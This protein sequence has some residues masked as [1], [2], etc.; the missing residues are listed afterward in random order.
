MTGPT[1]Q[2]M[3][4]L[5]FGGS[6]NRRFTQ[7]SPIL[8]EVWIKYAL[9]PHKAR[10]LILIPAR[11][12]NAGEFAN[13]LNGRLRAY[14]FAVPKPLT[15][16]IPSDLRN[17]K[18]ARIAHLPGVVAARLY[19]DE[20]LRLVL[21]ATPWW[22]SMVNGYRDKLETLGQDEDYSHLASSPYLQFG[23]PNVPFDLSKAAPRKR[24]A[25]SLLNK[26]AA[27]MMVI[28]RLSQAAMTATRDHSRPRAPFVQIARTAGAVAARF[29]G[30][31]LPKVVN[32]QF[33]L[34]PEA[35]R[36]DPYD[37]RLIAKSFL[38][39]FAGW[40][41]PPSH[42]MTEDGKKNVEKLGPPP[43]DQVWRVSINRDVTNAANRSTLA[44]KADAARLLFN[45]NCETIVWAVAD[46]G[47]D[48]HH[49]AFFDWRGT[50]GQS[51]VIKT[52]DFRE[53]RESLS[54]DETDAREELMERIEDGLRAK[55]TE[56]EEQAMTKEDLR[57]EAEKVLTA[58]RKRLYLGADI[59]WALLEPLVAIDEKFVKPP[60]VDHG[61][62]V[63]GILGADW[64]I[65]PS[66]GEPVRPEEVYRPEKLKLV[67]SDKDDRCTRMA[68]AMAKTMR[69]GR[70]IRPAGIAN[71]KGALGQLETIDNSSRRHLTGM[72]PDIRLYDFRVLRDDGLSDEFEV[73]AALQFIRFLNARAGDI[74]VHGVN[75]S[76]SIEH[77]VANYACGNT[78][79]CE[80]CDQLAA[81]GTVVVAAAGNRGYLDRTASGNGSFGCYNA[82]SITDPGNAE[83]AIT[84]GATHR[85]KPHVFGPSYFSSRGPTGDGRLKP[86]LVAPGEKIRAPVGI[87]DDTHKDGTSM[88]APHVSGAAAILMARH[89][90][91][92]GKP[93]KIKRILCE[94]ATDL[95]RERY[96][97][98]AG[99]L[100]VL[101]ALQSV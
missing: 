89:M 12:S 20:F 59:D 61:A 85:Y 26:L 70:T 35:D 62:H 46:S 44:C 32:G 8:P 92:V 60:T 76:L 11:S 40:P 34:H 53:L 71:P 91:L 38:C 67:E 75:L 87:D 57:F 72:C 90:E 93:A 17:N 10:D 98:G 74:K 5:I 43:C 31:D 96:F 30:K 65:N 39:M 66:T 1:R 4:Q 58:L 29:L 69:A 3:E 9:H 25:P 19:F 97:Q 48:A 24:S 56:A 45:V 78:P 27:D 63:A 47:I 18:R 99:M 13:E 7:D 52:Y 77:D 14:R 2:E 81:N 64:P 33:R 49:P 83:G 84:V 23:D 37:H 94:T 95:G 22:R 54:L 86:D 21:P 42:R 73:I 101:R 28:E 68:Q 80:E 88:A 36:E 79:I 50:S 15:D 55:M 16:L 41:G 51:R 6:E 82:M 100:D